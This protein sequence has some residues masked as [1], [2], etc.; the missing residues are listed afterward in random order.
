MASAVFTAMPLQRGGDFEKVGAPRRD[1]G[2]RAAA[3]R[4]PQGPPARAG[5]GR[6]RETYGPQ[7]IDGR[8]P[9]IMTNQRYRRPLRVARGGA[10]L[11][12]LRVSPGLLPLAAVSHTVDWS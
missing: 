11:A 3:V 7:L 6:R 2:L 10:N 8:V 1:R 9:P 12:N 5:A 4:L